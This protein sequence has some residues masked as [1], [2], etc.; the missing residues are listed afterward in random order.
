M[1][2][3]TREHKEALVLIIKSFLRAHGYDDFAIHLMIINIHTDKNALGVEQVS[4]LPRAIL[5]ELLDIIIKKERFN[6]SEN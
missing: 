5:L 6:I 1:N 4:T 3:L 2:T